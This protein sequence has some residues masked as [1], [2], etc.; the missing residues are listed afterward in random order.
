MAMGYGWSII[1]MMASPFVVM[2]ILAT[3]IVRSV[4]RASR[5]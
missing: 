2:G 3:V 1:A 5:E 4:K